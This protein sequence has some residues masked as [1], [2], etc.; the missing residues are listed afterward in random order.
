MITL[1]TL[2]LVV[3]F[4]EHIYKNRGGDCFSN[5]TATNMYWLK[6]HRRPPPRKKCEKNVFFSREFCDRPVQ[7]GARSGLMTHIFSLN[8]GISPWGMSCD[9]VQCNCTQEPHFETAAR[10]LYTLCIAN[11][12]CLILYGIS[13]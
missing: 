3:D 13:I 9:I 7:V 12:M 1:L 2:I 10:Q 8:I 5:R 11:W 6:L 4:N